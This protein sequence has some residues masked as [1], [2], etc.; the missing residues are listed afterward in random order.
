MCVEL[1]NETISSIHGQ[2]VTVRSNGPAQRL[3]QSA[4]GRSEGSG[5]ELVRKRG[6]EIAR[7]P[8]FRVSVT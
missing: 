2:N 3:I 5:S 1:D 4:P 7:M 6:F 8:L